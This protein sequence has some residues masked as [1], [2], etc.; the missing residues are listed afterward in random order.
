[1]IPAEH[2]LFFVAFS[3]SVVNNYC[4]LAH[5]HSV[6]RGDDSDHAVG[7]MEASESFAT[8]FRSLSISS[9]IPKSRPFSKSSIRGI[10]L[11]MV[12]R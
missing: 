3:F 4:C 11:K 2:S 10:A 12:S 7:L 8:L 9:A 1:M 6:V 5:H